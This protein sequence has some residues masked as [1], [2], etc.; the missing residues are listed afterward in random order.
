MIGS[1]K[2]FVL[3]MDGVIFRHSGV[4]LQLNS[5]VNLFVKKSVNKY[6]DDG[7]AFKINTQMYK[8]FGHTLIGLQKIYDKNLEIKDFNNYVYD[9][10]FINYI[11]R[12]CKEDEVQEDGKTFK[13][14]LKVCNN[15]KIPVYI[16]SNANKEWC[17][18]ILDKMNVLELMNNN[19]IITSDN[20]IYDNSSIKSTK[21]IFL[22][23]YGHT[24]LKVMDY[25]FKNEDYDDLQL[26]YV[27]DQ[28]KNLI[29]IMNNSIWKPILM[30]EKE[31]YYEKICTDNLYTIDDLS[32]LHMLM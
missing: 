25:I 23:P 7:K 21:Q 5:K 32:E 6:M 9:I 3:D 11:K 19:N 27:D 1:K 4:S 17:N 20:E 8:E 29:P 16:F 15:K 31:G 10:E 18:T 26:I 30:R 14:L 28:L 2:C 12:S 13:E 22:K 24:Y